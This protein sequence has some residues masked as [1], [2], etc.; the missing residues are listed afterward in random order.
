MT[1]D[2]FKNCDVK[3]ETQFYANIF[4]WQIITETEIN[5]YNNKCF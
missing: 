2:N 3:K 4:H 1:H 5:L